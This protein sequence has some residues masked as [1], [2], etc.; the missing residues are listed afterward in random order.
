MQQRHVIKNVETIE[1]IIQII[2]QDNLVFLSSNDL[3]LFD[4][5]SD[6][7]TSSSEEDWQK[8][9]KEMRIEEKVKEAVDALNEDYE[10]EYVSTEWEDHVF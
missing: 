8:K 3:D 1:T 7:C 9:E 4:S 6:S 5:D 10:N 2:H